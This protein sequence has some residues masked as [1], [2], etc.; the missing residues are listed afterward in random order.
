MLPPDDYIRI[1]AAGGGLDLRNVTL[2]G[3]DLI[4]IAAAAAGRKARILLSGRGRPTA[5]LVSIAA[6]GGGC[7]TFYFD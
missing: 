6:A 3:D 5:E 7:V 1:A 4:R 2:P